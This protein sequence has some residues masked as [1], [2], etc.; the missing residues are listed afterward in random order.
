MKT[1]ALSE[2]TH[3]NIAML[4]LEYGV[5]SSEEILKKLIVEH[6]KI[7]LLAASRLFQQKAKGMKAKDISKEAKKIRAEVY[8]E[9][10]ED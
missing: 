2:E 4:K 10:F 7:R 9:W 1:I 6:K 3:K 5:S 8:A